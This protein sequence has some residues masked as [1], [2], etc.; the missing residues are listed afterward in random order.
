MQINKMRKREGGFTLLEM[1]V[2]V[3]IIGLLAAMVVPNLM[4]NKGKADQKKTVADIVALESALDMFNLDHDRYPAENEGLRVLVSGGE[5]L[6]SGY[7]KRLPK[8][9]WGHDYLYRNPGV[10]GVIDIYTL[11]QDEKE[12]GEGVAADIGNWNVTHF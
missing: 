6:A 10:N 11:G 1:M 4:S 2:V 5:K 12:G 3:M 8:D 7:I 9:P